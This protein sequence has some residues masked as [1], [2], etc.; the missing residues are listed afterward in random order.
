MKVPLTKLP[1]NCCALS[2]E[3]FKNPVCT[4]EG[5]VFDIV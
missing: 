2:L 3:P 1:F 4:D 5:N